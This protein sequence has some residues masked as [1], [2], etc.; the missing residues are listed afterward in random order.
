MRNKP[1]EQ[2]RSPGRVDAEGRTVPWRIFVV[3]DDADLR[4]LLVRRLTAEGYEVQ[5]ADS[6]EEA[7][8]LVSRGQNATAAP[9]DLLLTDHRMPGWSG[10]AMLSEVRALGWTAPILLMTAFPS[11]ELEQL[12]KKLDATLLPKPLA[13]DLLCILIAQR[14]SR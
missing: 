14:L 4:E 7:F 2:A 1:R 13:L 12:A 6:A 3:D 5:Q 11:P 8:E 10:L 9:F